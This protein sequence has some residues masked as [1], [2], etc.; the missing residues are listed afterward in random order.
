MHVL[1]PDPPA[2]S[3][4][5]QSSAH[6]ARCLASCYFWSCSAL[7]TRR[8]IGVQQVYAASI[9]FGYFLRR[10]DTRFQLERSL[11]TLPISKDDAVERLE[12]LFAMAD[13]DEGDLDSV[14]ATAT[15][16]STID[17]DA[18]LP[19]SNLPVK[20]EKSALRKYVEVG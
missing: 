10:V 4:H 12:K 16:S 6:L 9:M 8:N 17:P 1:E 2:F 13:A 19:S 3:S 18:P 11:G 5:Q 15:A 14:P 7:P 20:K